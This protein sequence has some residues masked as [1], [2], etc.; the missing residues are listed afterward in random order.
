LCITYSTSLDHLSNLDLF[1]QGV[2]QRGLVDEKGEAGIVEAIHLVGSD[3][4]VVE[5]ASN[6]LDVGVQLP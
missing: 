4:Q 5:H 6:E 2:S 1:I 3:S